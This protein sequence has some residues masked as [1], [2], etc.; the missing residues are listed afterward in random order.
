VNPSV[1]E[2]EDILAS[3]F[4]VDGLQEKYRMGVLSGAHKHVNCFDQSFQYS[5][6][7]S[8]LRPTTV[9]FH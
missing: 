2:K 4:E 3:G 1:R 8:S 7:K 5:S 6:E 9:H